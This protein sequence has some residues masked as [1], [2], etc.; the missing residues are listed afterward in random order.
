MKLFHSHGHVIGGGFLIAGTTIGVGMLAL[1]IATGPGGFLPSIL[2]YLACWAFLLCTGLLLLEVCTW[3]PEDANLITMANRLLGKPG[4][5]ACWFIYLFLFEMVMISHVVGGGAIVNEIFPTQ[6]GFISAT[7]LYVILFSPVVYLG[8]RFVDRLNLV[9]FSGVLLSYLLF[10]VV[11]FAHV[12]LSKLSYINW[13]KAWPAIPILFTAFTYQVIIP[14]LV[15]YMK[16]DYKKV[17]QAIFL[18]TSI[19]LVVYIIWQVAILGIIPVQGP[20]GLAAAALKGENAV[21]PLK[22]FVGNPIVIGIGNAFAFF[23]MTASY[24]A[25]ALAFFDF[26]AD[27]LKIKKKG[28]NKILLCFLVFVPPLVIS[29]INQ[30]IFLVALG[31]AGG[32]SCAILFGLLPPIMVWIGRFQKGYTTGQQMPGGRL[33]L[34]LLIFLII[35][36]LGIE[37]YNHF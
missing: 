28:S 10:L 20:N 18:G 26:L 34:S 33:F 11:S 4:K 25:L 36:E 6:M 29:L 5:Y 37:V 1:P 16:R 14:T 8:T 7:I 35:A 13:K 19:P 23:T 22:H 2:I 32:I 3:M 31:Y 15:T 12:D 30:N 27:G 24:I 9:I 17:R 21:V